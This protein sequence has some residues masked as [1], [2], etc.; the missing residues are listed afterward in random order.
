[1]AMIEQGTWC[2]SNRGPLKCFILLSCGWYEV[3]Q[4]NTVVNIQ[5]PRGG[6]IQITFVYYFF[7]G[8]TATVVLK[9]R[10]VWLALSRWCG[11]KGRSCSPK[12]VQCQ[13]RSCMKQKVDWLAGWLVDW[14]QHDNVVDVRSG[15]YTVDSDVGVN[16]DVDVDYIHKRIQ[17]IWL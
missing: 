8:R 7:S 11:L 6:G 14:F 1:M 12:D 17:C 2:I 9:A 16:D 10:L 3:I 15:G 4:Y 13:S 5:D